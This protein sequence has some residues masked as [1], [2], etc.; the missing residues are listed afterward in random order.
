MEYEIY[1]TASGTEADNWA[2]RGIAN[3]HKHKGH[4][5]I[6]SKIEHHAI[7]NT[8]RYLEQQG[9]QVTYLDVDASGIIK[10]DQ[11]R[12]AIQPDTI[13][14]SIMYANNEIGTIQPIKEIGQIAHQHNILFHTD[15]VQA[16][17]QI[18]I[19]TNE[20]HIDLLSASAHK[21]YGPKGVGMLYIRDGVKISPFIHGGAQ[22][23]HLRAG[24][25][26]VPGIVGFGK[27]VELAHEKM[28]ENILKVTALRNYTI[29]H[30]LAEIP[31]AKL[32][33][34]T[35]K[36]LPN[37]IN[38]T[39]PFIDAQSLIIMLNE[40]GI[41]TSSGSACSSTML[42]PSHVLSAIGLQQ[43]IAN[44]SLRLTLGTK[45]TKAEINKFVVTLKEILSILIK[46]PQ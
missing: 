20:C 4:H 32:N 25:E 29:Q 11:L 42:T 34:H 5:I 27:A 3:A 7:L 2:L 23:N 35:T 21:L 18:P 39:I 37:N 30:I 28:P 43:D 44:S 13:L 40:K 8:C 24:T 16:F 6:T 22:E 46:R 45:N 9:Y 1:F 26:N 36:R 15:A 31:D 14:I 38:I 17:G 12:K 33:G 19:D 41:C 10:L